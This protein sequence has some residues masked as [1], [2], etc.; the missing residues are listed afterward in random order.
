[1]NTIN[2]SV[3]EPNLQ[4]DYGLLTSS[5]SGTHAIVTGAAGGLGKGI[6][7]ELLR[8]N[9][10]VV[11]ADID[12]RALH[13]LPQHPNLHI[14]H[15]DVTQ[16]AS[17]LALFRYARATFGRIDAVYANAGIATSGYLADVGQVG[18]QDTPTPPDLN[19]ID[20][21]VKGVLYTTHLAVQAFREDKR[22]NA[23]GGIGT[24]S[25]P[26]T[27]HPSIILTGSFT[28]FLSSP[29]TPAAYAASKHAVFSLMRSLATTGEYEG[30]RCNLVC[31]WFTPTA[32]VESSVRILLTGIGMAAAEPVVR[33]F[34]IAGMDT[35]LTGAALVIDTDGLFVIPD[36]TINSHC[37]QAF[38][39]RYLSV[40]KMQ[41]AARVYRT[42]LKL[43]GGLL[44]VLSLA[45]GVS[46]VL[47]FLRKCK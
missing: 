20:V 32:M 37:A 9:A 11:A 34:L 3:F 2:R 7:E 21:N 1:M 36:T 46:Y 40:L 6:V 16:Y 4:R 24:N 35:S 41:H 27:R 12:T 15:V 25:K 30:F 13:A 45:S 19:I 22:S 10:S 39:D 43:T 29:S 44:T 5:V 47:R 33:A 23:R 26:H 31:P 42:P 18:E 38:R 17:Q 28:S 14:H 8:H